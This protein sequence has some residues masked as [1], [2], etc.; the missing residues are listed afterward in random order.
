MGFLFFMRS[1]LALFVIALAVFFVG[2][3]CGPTFPPSWSADVL[4]RVL[5]DKTIIFNGSLV[6][7]HPNNRAYSSGL[8]TK[9]FNCYG[10]MTSVSLCD[11]STSWHVDNGVCTVDCCN[12]TSPDANIENDFMSTLQS[13][14]N[15][16]LSQNE[17]DVGLDACACGITHPLFLL[18]AAKNIGTCHRIGKEGTLYKL[19]F[20]APYPA[21]SL[22]VCM[23][24]TDNSP[25]FY[26]ESFFQEDV[27][28]EQ[29]IDITF[30]SFA[31]TVTNPSV[32]NLPQNCDCS[33]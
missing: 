10:T 19:T 27:G 25:I 4:G 31:P 13:H 21:I 30:F 23:D 29:V 22:W 32:F 28:E 24:D 15:K 16:V 6:L 7:D 17:N 14:W 5:I 20:P 2:T 1:L 18:K 3:Q 11:Y 26:H 8:L 9:G 12:G 33:I